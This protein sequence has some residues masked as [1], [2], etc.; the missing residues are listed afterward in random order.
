MRELASRTLLLSDKISTY[1]KPLEL[2]IDKLRSRVISCNSKDCAIE[3]EFRKNANSI[4]CRT[5][6]MATYVSARPLLLRK[7]S[8]NFAIFTKCALSN[9][10]K[11]VDRDEAD[12]ENTV[13]R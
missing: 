12:P 11:I 1:S 2:I 4:T 9:E 7:D 5:P 13:S 10:E 6:S 8:L 3:A